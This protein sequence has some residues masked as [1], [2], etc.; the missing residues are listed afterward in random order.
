MAGEFSKKVVEAVAKIPD[1]KVATY[2]QIAKAAE[3]PF[4]Y[5]AVGNVLYKL[6]RFNYH[7]LPFASNKPLPCHRVVRG[8]GKLGGYAK[9]PSEKKKRLQKEGIFFDKKNK[10]NL[11]LFG[12]ADSIVQK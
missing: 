10:I 8:D 11:N 9:S 3:S 7:S 6:Y 2:K 12:V 4:A 5:R 1:G